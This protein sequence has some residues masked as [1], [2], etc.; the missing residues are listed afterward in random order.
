VGFQ[1]VAVG[2][3]E[4]RDVFAAPFGGVVIFGA[5]QF[6]REVGLADLG[7]FEAWAYW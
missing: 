7:L 4:I 5:F 1:A 3:E 6:G 2:P